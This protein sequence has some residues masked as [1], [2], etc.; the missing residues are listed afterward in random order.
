MKPLPGLL[1]QDSSVAD[2]KGFPVDGLLFGMGTNIYSIYSDPEESATW[3]EFNLKEAAL[4]ISCMRGRGQAPLCD[5]MS[6]TSV[7]LIVTAGTNKGTKILYERGATFVEQSSFIT[8]KN[9]RALLREEAGMM[10]ASA[11]CF[12]C[13]LREEAGMRHNSTTARGS[14][15]P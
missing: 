13:L 14:S 7:P 10:L 6:Q 11:A 5:Y 1:S 15:A 8:A 2:A 3:E 4:V 9:L 12:C